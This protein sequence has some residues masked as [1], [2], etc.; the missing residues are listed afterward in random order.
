MPSMSGLSRC[1]VPK[2]QRKEKLNMFRNDPGSDWDDGA[3][4]EQGNDGT[5]SSD[6]S[7]DGTGSGGDQG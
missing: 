2:S 6:S 4:G 7:N 1:K 3:A 5:D